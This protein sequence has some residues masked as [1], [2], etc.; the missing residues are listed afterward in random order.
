M[1]A[2]ERI[3]CPI[4]FSETSRRALDCAVALARWY[5]ARLIVVHVF[6]NVPIADTVPSL[7]VG[8]IQPVSLRDVER[9]A[10]LTEMRQFVGRVPD[11]VPV[12]IALQ[13]APDVR[14]EILAAAGARRADLVVMG[15]HGRGGVQRL[16]LGSVADTVLRKAAC[17]VLVVPPHVD[18]ARIAVPFRRIVCPVDFSPASARSVSYALT[19]AQETDGEITLLH[20]IEIPPELREYAFPEPIDVD[21]IHSAAR[22][23]SLRRLRELVPESAYTYCTVHTEVTEGRPHRQVLRVAGERQADLIVMGTQGRS[24]VDR[25][26]FGSNTYA[27]IRDSACPVMTVPADAHRP[28]VTGEGGV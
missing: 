21:A 26:V 22:A 8:G 7:G 16:V 10:V 18:T 6:A 11:G 23:E 5:E 15:S 28:A 14:A 12:E 13:E 4:D 2:I 9:D 3:L 24:T 20:S 1:I 17:P 25:L 19:L 27:V